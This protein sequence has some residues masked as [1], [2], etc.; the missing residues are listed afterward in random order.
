MIRL[1]ILLGVLAGLFTN[2]HH[3][4]TFEQRFA[5]VNQLIP[6]DGQLVQIVTLPGAAEQITAYGLFLNQ[7]DKLDL[8]DCA[9][10]WLTGERAQQFYQHT[11]LSALLFHLLDM[12]TNAGNT[13][14]ALRYAELLHV[15]NHITLRQTLNASMDSLFIDN[16]NILDD[17]L[18]VCEPSDLGWKYDALADSYD[19]LRVSLV[20]YKDTGEAPPFD[21]VYAAEVI[22]A[23][24]TNLTPPLCEPLLTRYGTDN[25]LYNTTVI[26]L[27]LGRMS[28]HQ[29]TLAGL[30]EQ[31]ENA[32]FMLLSRS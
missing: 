15:R 18:P 5:I 31:S 12:A 17:G 24:H 10:G 27:L 28:T 2:H 7:L 30:L 26:T 23:M 3:P 1:L 19:N 20:H 14:D 29:P 16:R 13:E 8:P 9:D 22:A 32:L 11:Y 4:C 25:H 21:V 6:L